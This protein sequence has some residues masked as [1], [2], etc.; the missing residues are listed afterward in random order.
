MAYTG[1]QYLDYA[2][3]NQYDELIKNYIDTEDAKSFKAAVLN[4]TE[5]KLLLY[6]TIDKTDTPVE[7]PMD[8]SAL[9]GLI[10]SLG[11]AV[12]ATLDP[13]TNTY[14]VTLTGNIAAKTS[15]VTGLNQLDT[16]IGS[17]GTLTTTEKSTVVGAINEL[18]TA[19]SDLDA[20]VNVSADTINGDFYVL[21]GVDETNGVIAKGDE[22]LLKKIANTG[23]AEDLSTAA[24]DDSN[25]TSPIQLYPAG[26]AQTT[27][28]AIARDLNEL[29]IE[30]I[31]DIEKQTP[32]EE[33]YFATY[34]VKQN[35]AQ[36]GAKI[37]IPKDFLVKSATVEVVIAI[38]VPYAGAQVGDK[39]ID[40]V[41][42]VKEGATIDEHIYIPVNDLM[43]PLS[44][45]TTTVANEYELQVSISNT[46]QVT[47]TLNNIYAAKV[48]FVPTSTTS[49]I[50]GITNVGGALNTIDALIQ[51]M[52][53]DIDAQVTNSV[54][55]YGVSPLAVMTGITEANG[56]VTGVDSSE[57]DPFGTATAAYNAIGSISQ[58]S[59]E[60]LF[61]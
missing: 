27:L 24:I 14:S 61:S 40:F 1:K 23:A 45:N 26:T 48:Q 55:A 31:V 56:T 42:N 34:V 2:G 49:V 13:A 12:G 7:I 15:V 44:G 60:G 19:I 43:H 41:I 57:A 3:L 20:N 59:I 18:V 4:D 35:G 36:V 38:D 5:N 28:E 6:K 33:G 46:N 51:D 32:A 17:L 37:N 21:T 25:A 52:D 10:E 50:A 58:A 53:A 9:R 16:Y 39:Y 54:D 30:S 29:T 11:G 47:V 8:G 22:R